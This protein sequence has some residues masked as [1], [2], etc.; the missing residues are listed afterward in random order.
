VSDRRIDTDLPIG[1]FDSGVGGLTVLRAIRAALPRE[2]TVYLGDTARVPYGTKSRDSVLRYSLQA[3]DQLVRRGIKLL[4]VACNTASALSLPELRAHLAPLPV[5]GVVEP[6]AQAAVAASSRRRHLVL[7]TE[8]TAAQRAYTRAI[9]ALSPDAEVEE[10]ACSLF[11]ALA[12]EGWTDGPVAAAAA[13][14]Y[15]GEIAARPDPA[16]PHTVFLGCTHFPLLAAEIRAALG[17][18]PSIVDSATA[19]A[20]AVDALLER[21]RLARTAAASAELHLLVTDGA[22]RFA[23]LG[24]RFLGEPVAI[25]DVEVVDL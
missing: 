10:I 4:V 21:E 5:V 6:G 14:A 8:A 3:S 12:E 18:G 1:V 11:V 20:H 15:L 16:R 22:A 7:A 25:A 24:S 17:P 2:S 23:R 13:R 19:T 9:R